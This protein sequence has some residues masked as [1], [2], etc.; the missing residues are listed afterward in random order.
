MST[1]Q[2]RKEKENNT[3]LV[4]SKGSSASSLFVVGSYQKRKLT[5]IV[6]FLC[7]YVYNNCN[8]SRSRVVRGAS[9]Q[10]CR[11]GLAGRKKFQT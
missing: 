8:R 2:R 9:T 3:L 11:V 10:R 1:S 5:N 6:L 7:V 4:G